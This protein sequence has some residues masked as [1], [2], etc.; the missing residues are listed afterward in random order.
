MEVTKVYNLKMEFITNSHY[1][2]FELI[3][4]EILL[5]FN[6]L[7]RYGEKYFNKYIIQLETLEKNIDDLISQYPSV[8][9]PEFE[10]EV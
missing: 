8:E 5:E 1:L 7:E 10:Y 4:K 9:F 6:P 2:S 3:Q